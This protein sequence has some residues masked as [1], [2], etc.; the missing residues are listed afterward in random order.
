MYQEIDHLEMMPSNPDQFANG[1][2][3]EGKN[4]SDFEG[5][6]LTDKEDCGFNYYFAEER[7]LI[8]FMD[9]SRVISY[10][11]EKE[12]YMEPM[13]DSENRYWIEKENYL[14]NLEDNI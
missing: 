9:P 10:L 2:Q 12:N 6:C 14:E 8:Y 13:G 3:F 4:G 5:L 1:C 7:E 11:Q